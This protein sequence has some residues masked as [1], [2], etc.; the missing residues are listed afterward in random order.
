[1][2]NQLKL[3]VL[4][5]LIITLKLA[6]QDIITK[7]NGDD[8]KSKVIEITFTEIKYKRFDNLEGPIF[9]LPKSEILIIRYENGS[10]DIFNQEKSDSQQNSLAS[11]TQN[12]T[13]KET[14]T[15]PSVSQNASSQEVAS[16]TQTITLDDYNL[17]KIDAKRY[18]RGYKPAGTGTLATGLVAGSILS[19][20]PAL[21]TTSTSPEDGNLNYPDYKKMNN[22]D[23]RNGYTQ[24]A[25]RIKKSK[26]WNNWAIGL[27][28]NVVA[29]FI[30]TR[31]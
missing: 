4:F 18:Y 13:N 25:F 19:L 6:T 12:S 16:S 7:K 31:L 23:Y 30:Y 24:E 15:A 5:T 21:L 11:S 3:T 9:T 8:V 10:K 2:K 28:I 26:V 22:I 17:G 20:I 29:Y 1:M 27:G 14:V